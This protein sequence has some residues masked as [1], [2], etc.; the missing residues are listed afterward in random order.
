MS[1]LSLLLYAFV[2][3]FTRG[4][5]LQF[6]NPKDILYCIMVMSIFIIPY[7]TSNSSLLFHFVFPALIGYGNV[8]LESLWLGI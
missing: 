4:M 8:Q 2:T 3:S 5:L 1:L 7:P 6:I